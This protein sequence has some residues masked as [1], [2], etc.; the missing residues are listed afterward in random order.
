MENLS[1]V[2]VDAMVYGPYSK[3]PMFRPLVINLFVENLRY[4]LYLFTAFRLNTMYMS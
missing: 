4:I 2:D 3:D 1:K